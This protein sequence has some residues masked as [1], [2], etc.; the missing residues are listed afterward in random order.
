MIILDNVSFY[1]YLDC[2]SMF[3]DKSIVTVGISLDIKQE[4][5]TVTCTYWSEEKQ[6]SKWTKRKT[7]LMLFDYKK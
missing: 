5:Y 7:Y 2:V 6:Q 4:I 3:N 1:Y